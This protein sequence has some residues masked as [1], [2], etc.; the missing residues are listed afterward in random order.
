LLFGPGDSRSHWLRRASLANASQG[1]IRVRHRRGC[2]VACP[3]LDT[4]S[5][6][7]ACRCH[8][9]P[10]SRLSAY[11]YFECSAGELF[12]DCGGEPSRR[13]ASRVNVGRDSSAHLHNYSRCPKNK[14]ECWAPSSISVKGN[15]ESIW[16][17]AADNSAQ[18]LGEKRAERICNCG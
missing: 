14:S 8:T 13:T 7:A 6:L 15:R 11:R 18:W 1:P 4:L 9:L 3:Q 5:T 2:V 17:D 16:D 12:A 10:H